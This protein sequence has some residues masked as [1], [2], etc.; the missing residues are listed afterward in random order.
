MNKYLIKLANHLDK[1]GLHKEA[2]YVD[3]ILK[4]S[5]DPSSIDYGG[6]PTTDNSEALPV[7]SPDQKILNISGKTLGRIN[8]KQTDLGSELFLGLSQTMR[9]EI[10]NALGSLGYIKTSI[11]GKE[12]ICHKDDKTN[13][14]KELDVNY[15]EFKISCTARGSKIAKCG[16]EIHDV[17]KGSKYY[18]ELFP[19]SYQDKKMLLRDLGSLKSNIEKHQE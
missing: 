14:F 11:D 1:K 17:Y 6:L 7:Q 5:A 12:Y 13:S 8:S 4:T 18:H 10:L 2:D 16:L 15:F 19:R 9:S 3:W